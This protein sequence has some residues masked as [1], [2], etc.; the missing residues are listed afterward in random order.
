MPELPEIEVLKRSLKK[1]LKFQRILKIKVYNKNLRYKFSNSI[2]KNLNKR[3]IHDVTRISKYLVIHF[4]F[5]KKLLV[6]LGMS[7][8][9]HILDKKNKRSNASFY[10]SA[11]LPKKHNHIV[12]FFINSTKMVY[13]DPRRF[14]Y[15]KLLNNNYLFKKPFSCLGPD[16]LS[17]NFNYNYVKSFILSRKINLKKLLMNQKFV[18]GIGNIYANEILYSCK[19]KPTK[20]V[21]FLSKKNILDIIYQSKKVLNKA[22]KYGGSS[23]KDF[24]DDEGNTGV[25]QQKFNVYGKIKE[26]C[27]RYGCAGYIK[28]IIISN[29]S[30]FY[31]PKCQV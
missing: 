28:K 20:S 18:S 3:I 5:S 19:L 4:N 22:I 13:N 8:T 26:K 21:D 2:S 17:Y 29:R 30:S 15:F 25:F 23:I 12:F 6:H 27:P 24:V 10:S 1:K 11:F 14:G 9:I 31:C 7:G 16:P